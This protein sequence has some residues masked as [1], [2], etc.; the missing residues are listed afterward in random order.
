VLDEQHGL[1]GVPELADGI[2]QIVEKGT[3]DA[4]GSSRSTS[5]GSRMSTRTN[6]TS[7]CCP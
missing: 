6:S 1:A 4:G 7:F 5:E 2:E 3:V